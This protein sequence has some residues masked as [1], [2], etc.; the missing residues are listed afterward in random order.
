[1]K[2]NINNLEAHLL[3][4]LEYLVEG[5]EE[6]IIITTTSGPFAKITLIDPPI[7]KRIG[8]AKEEMEDF[9]ISLEDFNNLKLDSFDL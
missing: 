9:D 7:S 2:T 5:K 6:E 8:A 4:Y 3:K 1:M